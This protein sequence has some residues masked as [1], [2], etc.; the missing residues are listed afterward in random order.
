MQR[1]AST[2]TMIY[3]FSMKL[4]QFVIVLLKTMI[5]PSILIHTWSHF[6][7]CGLVRILHFSFYL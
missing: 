2:L 5:L 3:N 6:D 1:S 4:I 7:R